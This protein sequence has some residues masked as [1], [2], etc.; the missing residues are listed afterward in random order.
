MPGRAMSFSFD[1]RTARALTAR[2]GRA[3]PGRVGDTHVS[4]SAALHL[5]VQRYE[6]ILARHRPDLT[7]AEEGCLADIL[8]STWLA[9]DHAP[10]ALVATIEDA[11]SRAERES[12]E[13]YATKWSIEPERLLAKLRALDYAGRV[14]VCDLVERWWSERA[15]A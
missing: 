11:L 13:D 3:V 12:G 9:D 6:A 5:L 14:A 7:E 4:R 8:R 10:D 15:T 1:P 2:A